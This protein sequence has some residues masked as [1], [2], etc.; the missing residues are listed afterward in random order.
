MIIFSRPVHDPKSA[1][2]QRS[3]WPAM[4]GDGDGDPE[5]DE[6][7]V[8]LSSPGW[9]EHRPRTPHETAGRNALVAGSQWDI[10]RA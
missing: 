4:D 1:Q 5:L 9:L 6:N 2:W 7:L 3:D 8:G 10:F